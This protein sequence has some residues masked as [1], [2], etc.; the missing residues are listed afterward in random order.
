MKIKRIEKN[1]KDFLDLLLIGDEQESMIDRYLESGEMFVGYTEGKAVAVCVVARELPGEIEVKNLAVYEE[2]RRKGYGR[3]MLEYVERE[4]GASTVWLGTGESP[5]T[6]NFYISCGYSFSHRIPDF[7]TNNYDNPVI[8]EGVIL[9]DMV[10]LKKQLDT[11]SD[12]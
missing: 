5:T 7:F 11:G 1:K 3:A 6:L 9:K 12:Y 2:F 4:C 10:Y 8:D